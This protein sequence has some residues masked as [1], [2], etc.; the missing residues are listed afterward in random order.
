MCTDISTIHFG[1][2]YSQNPKDCRPCK[3]VS[4]ARKLAVLHRPLKNVSFHT[5]E[6]SDSMAF[7][8]EL[9]LNHLVYHNAGLINLAVLKIIVLS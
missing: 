9:T 5:S 6:I 3:S 2:P 8:Q 7:R 4:H 1:A